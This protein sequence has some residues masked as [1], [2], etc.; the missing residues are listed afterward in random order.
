MYFVFLGFFLVT[1]LK[2]KTKEEKN[3]E[4][5]IG[6]F[7]NEAMQFSALAHLTNY[8]CFLAKIA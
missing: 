3:L 1:S 6:E 7:A 8:D 2:K 4:K 5:K